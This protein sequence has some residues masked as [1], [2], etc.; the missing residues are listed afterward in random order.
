MDKKAGYEKGRE[1]SM[2]VP[3]IRV[4]SN[5]RGGQSVDACMNNVRYWEKEYNRWLKTGQ[6]NCG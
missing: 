5:L 1:K 3:Q 6:A 4:R 2:C